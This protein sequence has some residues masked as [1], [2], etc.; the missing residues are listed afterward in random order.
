MCKSYTNT[1]L[2]FDDLG[3]VCYNREYVDHTP[4]RSSIIIMMAVVIVITSRFP[5]RGAIWS[6]GVY[7]L[8]RMR[9]GFSFDHPSSTKRAQEGP[10]VSTGGQDTPS[11]AHETHCVGLSA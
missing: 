8:V 6:S 7:I 11:S 9:N 2:N 4:K 1:S 3:T 10:R 5:M